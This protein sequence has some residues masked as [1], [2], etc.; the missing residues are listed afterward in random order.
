MK[1]KVGDKVMVRRDLKA[2]MNIPF[3]VMPS[4]ASLAGRIATITRAGGSGYSIDI[5]VA[6]FSWH[7]DMFEPVTVV[8]CKPRNAGLSIDSRGTC[9]EIPMAAA[10]DPVTGMMRAVPATDAMQG[11]GHPLSSCGSMVASL[12]LSRDVVGGM[13]RCGISVTPRAIYRVA[14]PIETRKEIRKRLLKL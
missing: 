3:G 13:P 14:N 4:M 9:H 12:S 6:G 11:Y 7:E 10:L 1:Y 5:D 8:A 2:G